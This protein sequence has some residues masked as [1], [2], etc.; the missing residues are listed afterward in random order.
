M[1]RKDLS[2]GSLGRSRVEIL[3]LV[4]V[5]EILVIVRQVGHTSEKLESAVGVKEKGSGT[6]LR[7]VEEEGGKTRAMKQQR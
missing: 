4:V 5:G 7:R 6:I 1:G 2:L 3:L